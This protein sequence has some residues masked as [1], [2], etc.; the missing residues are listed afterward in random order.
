MFIGDVTPKWVT[1]YPHIGQSYN[2]DRWEMF[3]LPLGKPNKSSVLCALKLSFF[4][5][6][7]LEL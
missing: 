2:G 4:Q 6:F 5:I 3:L 7:Y 1:A